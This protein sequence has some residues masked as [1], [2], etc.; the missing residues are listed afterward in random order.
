MLNSKDKKGMISILIGGDEAPEENQSEQDG[1]AGA[2]MLAEALGITIDDEKAKSLYHGF[3]MMKYAC[4]SE[5]LS[6]EKT[7]TG[8][9]KEIN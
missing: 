5:E 6:E 3:E 7:E 2:K 9:S 8:D 4:E 1:I